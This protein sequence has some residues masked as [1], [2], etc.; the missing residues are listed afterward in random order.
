MNKLLKYDKEYENI[1]DFC[2][3]QDRK[4]FFTIIENKND[5]NKEISNKEY[6]NK[7]DFYAR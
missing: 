5:M 7:I 6:E 4:S 2:K 1:I 3:P